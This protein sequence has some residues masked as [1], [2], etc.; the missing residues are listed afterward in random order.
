MIHISLFMHTEELAMYLRYVR[1]LD[2]F[3][4][5]DYNYLKKLFQD[6]FDRKGYVED[7]VFDWTGKEQ[8]CV[9]LHAPP[10]GTSTSYS[11]KH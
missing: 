4:K 6:L 8:V 7:G 11:C 9:L 10:T 1:R 3:E 5:P 2:F